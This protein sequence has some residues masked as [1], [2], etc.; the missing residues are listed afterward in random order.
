MKTI[1]I[2]LLSFFSLQ[3]SGQSWPNKPVRLIVPAGQGGTIDPLSRF[4]ADAYTKAFGQ[5]DRKSVV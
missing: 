1:L 2:L 5:T 4:F 3:V